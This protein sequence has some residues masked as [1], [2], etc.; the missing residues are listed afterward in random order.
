M[1]IPLL[2]QMQM[3]QVDGYGIDLYCINK[4]G[5][6]FLTK[7]LAPYLAHNDIRIN[8]VVPGI[9]KTN[10]L[11]GV[12]PWD[13]TENVAYFHIRFQLR[14]R[15]REKDNKHRPM[16]AQIPMERC[17]MM[18]AIITLEQNRA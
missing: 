3:V 6:L 9:V 1:L 10:F 18:S 11:Q 2:T 7:A 16:S 5:L 12:Q 15:M 8:R 4:G 13:V 17:V 14:Q